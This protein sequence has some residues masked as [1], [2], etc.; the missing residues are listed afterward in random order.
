MKD[1]GQRQ[2]NLKRE[3][4]MP[5]VTQTDSMGKLRDLSV[6]QIFS[7]DVCIKGRLAEG[8]TFHAKANVLLQ[9]ERMKG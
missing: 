2:R 6:L 3:V 9:W 4:R 7:Q 5:K 1:G 8:S